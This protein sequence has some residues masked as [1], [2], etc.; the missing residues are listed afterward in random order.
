MHWSLCSHGSI[1]KSSNHRASPLAAGTL[2]LAHAH[3]FI[4]ELTE[5]YHTAGCCCRLVRFCLVWIIPHALI[6][7]CFPRHSWGLGAARLA[8]QAGLVKPWCEV[9][10]LSTPGSPCLQN[11]V[12]TERSHQ[13]TQA[14]LTTLWKIPSHTVSSCILPVPKI[15]QRSRSETHAKQ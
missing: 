4:H 1:T 12:L 10:R 3:S 9:G 15:Q 14:W 13:V 11:D 6:I 8:S 2:A 5:S 7:P